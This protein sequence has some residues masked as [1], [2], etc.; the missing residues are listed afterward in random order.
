MNFSWLEWQ[1]PVA[2]WWVF[3]ASVSACNILAWIFT[4]KYLL[5]SRGTKANAY[6]KA[7]VWLSAAYVFG[8][9]FRSFLPRADVQRIVLFD[10]WFSSVLVGR[11]VA[12][13]AELCFVAQWAIVLNRLSS[14]SNCKTS[15]KISFAIVPLIAI[16]ECFSWYAVISTHYLG[17]TVEESIWGISYALIMICQI[18]LWRK[19]KGALKYI[20]GIS[21]FGSLFYVIF[22]FTVDVPM[23]FGR[24]QADRLAGKKLLGLFAGL[25]DLNS[26]WQVTYDIAAWHTEIPWMSLYFSIA[27]WTSLAL[28][29]APTQKK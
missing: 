28:C 6:T 9:A 17:N 26:R 14:Q 12:T 10:T 16:A 8:C 2:I 27:V 20:L 15:E 1:N 22:M 23:Y 13:I 18:L 24:W 5:G 11:S 7:L 4:F 29:Y 3:L 25:H 21:A 19:F